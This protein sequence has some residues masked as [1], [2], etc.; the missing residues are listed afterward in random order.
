MNRKL[1]I[2]L[3]LALPLALAAPTA[4][5]AAKAPAKVTVKTWFPFGG[6][7][8]WTGRVKSDANACQKERFV[9]I[10]LRQGE[11]NAI[12]GDG[13]TAKRG[14]GK[15]IYEIA[16]F[17]PDPGEYFAFA[18]PTPKCKRAESKIFTYPDDL[19]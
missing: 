3:C 4:A 14:P 13:N 9:E 11:E 16:A 17:E 8:F 2:G 19:P 10:Y 6:A 1:A 12:V 18:P 5:P 15:W 7:G